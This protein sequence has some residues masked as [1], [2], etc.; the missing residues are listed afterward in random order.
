MSEAVSAGASASGTGTTTSTPGTGGQSEVSQNSGGSPGQASQTQSQGDQT[1][2]QAGAQE[3]ILAETDLDAFIEQTINGKKEKIKLRDALKGYGMEK[4][5][6]QRMQEAAA[7]S[8][9]AEQLQHLMQTDFAKYCEITGQDPNQFLRQQLA[10]RKEIAEE[11]LAKE[12]EL[13]QMDPHQRKAMEL[14]Q[15]LQGLKERDMKTKQ[16]LIDEIK[17]LVD[18]ERLPK[19]LENATPEQLRGYLAQQQAEF[20]R[21]VDQTSNELLDAWQKTGLPREK[22]FGAWMAQVMMDHERKSAAHEKQTGQK[23][24]PLQ[25]EQA[26]AKVKARFLRSSQ[27][28]YDQ[29]DGSQIVA[30][31]GEKAAE[32]IREHLV[33]LASGNSGPRFDTQN[34]QA[35]MASSEQPRT[36]NQMEFRKLHGLA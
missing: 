36:L 6:Q 23:L 12:Y 10:S 33:K 1:Q 3:R 2:A 35:P 15:E 7:K 34:R 19:G 28:L 29:M 13:Q 18:P 17:K 24:D 21:G 14:E 11:I 16:P 26:A 32:K 20:K 5:A 31:I 4:T 30:A 8:K 9:R 25:P 27:A 22:D